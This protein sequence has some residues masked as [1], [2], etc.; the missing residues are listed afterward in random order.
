MQNIAAIKD[1]YRQI[2]RNS[3][4][5]A[6]FFISYYSTVSSSE[7]NI[8]HMQGENRSEPFTTDI[9]IIR[10]RIKAIGKNKSVGSGDWKRATV[11]PIHKGGDRSLI[12]NYRPV[13]LFSVVCKQ[14]EHAIPSYLRRGWDKNDWLYEG[15][16]GFRLGYSCESQVITVC[17]KI[18]D[19]LDNAARIDAI[20]ADF[21]KAFDLVP[22]GRLLAKIANSGVD[23]RVV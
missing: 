21:S 19:C 22:H 4:E 16:H 9:K 20:I 2:I 14:M 5:K 13:S 12:T 18:A 8:P 1:S 15:R 3:I 10:S 7:R 6:N 11:I 17:Q 23:S